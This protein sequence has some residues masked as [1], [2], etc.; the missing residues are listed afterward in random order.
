[1]KKNVSIIWNFKYLPKFIKLMLISVIL[2]FFIIPLLSSGYSN[3]L[4][5]EKWNTGQSYDAVQYATDGMNIEFG[6]FKGH[7]S[8]SSYNANNTLRVLY[9]EGAYGGS[10]GPNIGAILTPQNE[11]FLGYYLWFSENFDWGGTFEGG[12]LP[13][14]AG[15]GYCSGGNT[16]DGTNGF[17][18]RYLWRENGRAVLYLYHMDKPGVYA[19]DLQLKDSL[20][21]NKYFQK[22]T[23]H[24]MVQRVKINTGNNNDGEVEVWMDGEQVLLRTNLRFVNNGN[25]VD[26]FYFNTFH[27]GD[28][29]SWAPSSTVWTYF[30]NIMITT[31]RNEALAVIPVPP[32]PAPEI[33]PPT[34]F[35][36]TPVSGSVV[37]RNSIINVVATASDNVEVTK[38][39][40]YNTGVLICT[41]VIAPYNCAWKV[42]KNPNISYILQAKAHD[43]A[44][45]TGV[46]NI[47]T[48]TSK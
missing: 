46:S 27:G 14:L 5:F 42:P 30:D 47:V 2:V 3:L 35:I 22:G 15:A 19:E 28:D 13:G 34:V 31:D 21:N 17:T 44:G 24:H 6:S 48:V 45:N 40:F 39:E 10:S 12:K 7:G 18:A 32:Q 29:V 11:Y 38:V 25:K 33:V 9:P 23:W 41:D 8:I 37:K 20:G 43:A 1:M 16:C 4:N 26:R 36:T